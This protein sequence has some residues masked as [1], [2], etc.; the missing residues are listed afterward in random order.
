MNGDLPQSIADYFSGKNARDVATAL[1]GFA[2]DATVLD[3][4]R[5][6]VGHEAIT[7]WMRETAAQYS[8]HSTVL[9]AE[10][11]GHRILVTAQ[12]SGT[13]PGSP[14]VLRYAFSIQDGL[15]TQLTIASP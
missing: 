15:I 8:D 7:A 1:S 3:E 5:R 12:V 14:I 4:E 9:G 13:F 6:H 10:A 11:E 2:P